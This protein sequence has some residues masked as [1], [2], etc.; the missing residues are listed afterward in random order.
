MLSIVKNE[1]VSPETR[2]NDTDADL[3]EQEGRR[4]KYSNLYN[5][6]LQE[7]TLIAT[8]NQEE[9]TR[10]ARSLFSKR[11]RTLYNWLSPGISKSRLK[12]AV[13]A[14]WDRLPSVEKDF[15]ISQVLG[16][17]GVPSV[18]VMVNPQILGFSCTTASRLPEVPT[19]E[20]NNDNNNNS[21]TNNNNNNIMDAVNSMSKRKRQRVHRSTASNSSFSMTGTSD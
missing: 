8:N 3:D 18:K 20:H 5:G 17:F 2:N 14:A 21:N 4:R 15:Y 13:S 9:V 11:T 16:R 1:P 19:N 10:A 6:E 12:T 7:Q